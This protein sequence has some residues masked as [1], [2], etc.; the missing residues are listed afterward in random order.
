MR[1]VMLL[2]S[3]GK[4]YDPQFGARPVKRIQRDVL[5][6]LSKEI[7]AVLSPLTVLYYS[8]LLAESWF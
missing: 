5:N 4:G 1:Q 8:M 7:L 6:K 2:L 3:G